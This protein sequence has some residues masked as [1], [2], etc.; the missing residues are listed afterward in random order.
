MLEASKIQCHLK[1]KVEMSDLGRK[2]NVL[3]N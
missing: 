3:T 2:F 1:H